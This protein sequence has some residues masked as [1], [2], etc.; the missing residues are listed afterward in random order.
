MKCGE[1]MK[2]SQMGL[3]NIKLTDLNEMYPAQDILLKTGQIKQYGSGVYGMDNIVLRVQ[4]NIENV[5]KKHFDRIGGIEVQMPLIQQKELWER[6]ARYDKYVNDGVMLTIKTDKLDYCLAPTA[7]EAI[8][9]FVENR[10][11][12][13]NQLP[14][15]LYQIGTK[16]RN[17]I[18]NRG[19]LYRGKEFNMFDLY[20]FDKN[21]V[22]MEKSY[23]IMKQT[24]FKVFEELGLQ[25]VAVAADNGAIGG[26]ISEEIMV[27]SNSG[28]DTIL[29]DK[30]NKIG[31]NEEVLEKENYESYLKDNYNI[32]DISS[33]EKLKAL[34]LGH[35][36]ALGD[37]YSESMNIKYCDEDNSVKNFQMGCYGIGV[38]RVLGCI[39]EN[40]TLKE[41]DKVIGFSLPLSVVPYYAYI[42]YNENRNQEA[43]DLY[44]KLIE[45]DIKVIIDDS[46]FS[47]GN[48]IRNAKVLG[49]PY[50]IILGNNTESNKCEIEQTKTET[51][52]IFTIN[53]AF[54]KISE[55]QNTKKDIN[56]L[57]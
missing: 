34:E 42:I 31:L 54:E 1:K 24:Y 45:N 56:F 16:F 26:S 12:S 30:E 35:I 38:S 28:E 21:I 44:N 18:R 39:Y 2:I 23:N 51:K 33:L 46:K 57:K 47:I 10:V 3:K 11:T 22:D 5:I 40:N 55:I 53:E 14:L 15:Y 17:E 49:I 41:N 36:F 6:S 27:I 9:Y 48:K 25:S 29:Y 13:H 37:K 32:T 43:N 20:T 19:Y 4:D 52:D 7:E 8:T 50:I